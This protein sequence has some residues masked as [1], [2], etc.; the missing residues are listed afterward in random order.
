MGRPKGSRNKPE[1]P[2]QDAQESVHGTEPEAQTSEVNEPAEVAK[3]PV[4]AQSRCFMYH[5]TEGKRIF[6]SGE[7]I[8]AGWEDSPAKV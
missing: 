3:K 6:E 4:L 5:A 2:S 8:P 1:I 7:A